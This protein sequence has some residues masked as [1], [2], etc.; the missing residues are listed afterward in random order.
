M[1]PPPASAP[2]CPAV[3]PA[4]PAA[5]TPVA[6]VTPVP[7]PTVFAPDEDVRYGS[8]WRYVLKFDLPSRIATMKNALGDE[9]R[10]I[11]SFAPPAMRVDGQGVV[12]GDRAALGFLGPWASTD[13]IVKLRSIKDTN[14]WREAPPYSTG[15][16]LVEE[17][18][19]DCTPGVGIVA[20]CTT[21]SFEL[22]Y[23]AGWP[24]DMKDPGAPLDAY[25]RTTG[26]PKIGTWK[27]ED[28][29]RI[30]WKSRN[31]INWGLIAYSDA[32]ADT[33]S[34]Y[35]GT[36]SNLLVTAINPMGTDVSDILNAMRLSRDGG[37]KVGGGTPTRSALEKAEQQL[38]DTFSSDPL[39]LCLRAYGV[40][41]VTD[42]QS[43]K[44]NKGTK[45][46]EAWG[47]PGNES[48]PPP[49][50]PPTAAEQWK[51]FPPGISDD[52]WNLN[53]TTPCVGKRPRDV[54]IN[55]RT[56][57]IGF[58]SEVGK[59]ELNYTAYKGRT[60]A[61]SPNKGAGF[62]LDNDPRL[63]RCTNWSPSETD[64]NRVCTAYVDALY[65]DSLD[66]AF[67]ADNSDNLVT[68]FAE[69]TAAAATGD[70]ATGAPVTG[71]ITAGAT[72]TDNFVIL[73][74]TQYPNWEGHLY[75]FDASKIRADGG[76]D[77]G[78][79]VWDAA[80]L[81]RSRDSST[82]HIYSWNPSSKALV[83]VNASSLGTLQAIEPTLTDKVIDFIR[84]NDGDGAPRS[85]RLG[86]LINTVPSIV[87]APVKYGQG[88]VAFNHTDFE[89]AYANRR[90]LIWIGA[91]DGMLHAFDFDTGDEIVALMPPQLLAQQAT[92]YQNFLDAK[93]TGTGQPVAF[94]NIYG[95]AGSLRFSD[96]Y[97]PDDP[98]VVA[99]DPNGR[100][101]TLGLM[102]L[103][104]GGDLVA[105][106]DITHPYS[107]DPNYGNFPPRAGDLPNAPVQVIWQKTGTDLPGLGATWS[108]PALGPRA[109]DKWSINFGAG[110][111]PTSVYDAQKAPQVFQLNPVDGSQ[112]G[113][114]ASATL[115]VDATYPPWVGSQAFA[116]G[117]RFQ[118]LASAFASDNIVTRGLQADLNGRIWFLD[119][120]D[121][122]S[123]G[124]NKPMIGIDASAVAKQSQ[125]LYYPPAAGGAGIPAT[126]GCNLYSFGSGTF[127][128][129]SERVNGPNTGAGGTTGFVPSLYFAANDKA[130]YDVAIDPDKILKVEIKTINR[131]ERCP[132]GSTTC[133]PSTDV[134][135][136]GAT[137]SRFSQM[138]GAP[139]LLID[140]K[141]LQPNV[142]IFVIYDPT[143]GCYGA[144]YAV[145]VKWKPNGC[146]APL[147]VASGTTLANGAS[148]GVVVEAKFAGEGAA[149]GLTAVGDLVFTGIAGL[150]GA[151][152][153]DL[154]GITEPSAF[155]LGQRFR[156][157]WWKELK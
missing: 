37:I 101:R 30:I 147:T 110:Y 122:S 103:A 121:I 98:A 112:I 120:N 5:V 33:C 49:L 47:A 137:L 150:G 38:I 99:G 57:V 149:S 63:R 90:S 156:P 54:G 50:A 145:T 113:T 80:A 117:V 135:D 70:Y 87:A 69:I 39:Y 138:T 151:G 20:G 10:I 126:A 76:R 157:I 53:L 28:P 146:D 104:D 21:W 12:Q 65:D 34:N 6:T 105:A 62:D 22:E 86:P 114:A 72:T 85:M 89:V 19:P 3:T 68:A 152:Q 95:V 118:H 64:P 143:V 41:L 55:P 15:P 18:N 75:K 51:L 67:F 31:Q 136:F 17:I 77:P 13:T 42:G 1:F 82:R 11:P 132:A 78:Y 59:C 91:N 26:K 109:T 60:D 32:A 61:N 94:E 154:Y 8:K 97:F 130:R 79:R 35:D 144:S 27:E 25:D 134:T 56:W 96:V 74:S 139:L 44:C 108:L 83:E 127:Y 16:Y 66:Y 142:G 102:T 148:G 106:I 29:A 116:D 46:N 124:A 115:D 153:A 123:T 45:L 58:G 88:T 14:K 24:Q 48:C 71:P 125:P 92:L 111:D 43:N 129:E 7:P 73:S 81:L 84:G 133:T 140:P 119:P 100:W 9:V 2:P 131:P 52:L 40:I 128:E 141:G 36:D 107:T 93:K 155:G 4:P 23:P